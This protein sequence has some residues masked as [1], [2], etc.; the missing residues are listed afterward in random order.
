MA[1]RVHDTPNGDVFDV[2]GRGELHLG[3]L[4]ENMRREG[5]EL[6]VGRPRVVKN[7][8][9]NLLQIH[10]RGVS[11]QK[12]LDDGRC[13]NGHSGLRIFQKLDQLFFQ[14]S[15]KTA[16][17][18]HHDLPPVSSLGFFH[19]ANNRRITVKPLIMVK[20]RR[21]FSGTF[22]TRKTDCRKSTK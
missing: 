9:R 19:F 13:E 8:K 11:E 10:G 15:K 1:L 18:F 3:I 21:I 5:Y 20:F 22:P 6:A 4:L 7:G 17:A 16:S 14:Q 2:A 12:Q